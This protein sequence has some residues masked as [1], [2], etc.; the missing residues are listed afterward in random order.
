M[1]ARPKVNQEK[2][3]FVLSISRMAKEPLHE[4]V[5]VDFETFVEKAR[6]NLVGCFTHGFGVAHS[7]PE[8]RAVAIAAEFVKRSYSMMDIDDERDLE[9]LRWARNP[10]VDK[11]L[12]GRPRRSTTHTFLR[13][14]S[15]IMSEA[16]T[17]SE[18]FFALQGIFEESMKFADGAIARTL[19]IV[20]DG[21]PWTDLEVLAQDYL[22][23][24]R[25]AKNN[26]RFPPLPNLYESGVSSAM[27]RI[28]VSKVKGSFSVDIG[29]RTESLGW[30][31]GMGLIPED[32]MDE[33]KEVKR[34]LRLLP[35]ADR[36]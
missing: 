19:I 11:G 13:M 20:M 24:R 9:A 29:K 1:I 31:E 34:G 5:Q 2:L 27:F 4:P 8:A 26:E 25:K 14:V 28:V 18:C 21:L 16:P 23:Y 17:E 10:N 36:K 12:Q 22:D 32:I 6:Q 35:P 7:N 30:L 3:S 33:I 15:D